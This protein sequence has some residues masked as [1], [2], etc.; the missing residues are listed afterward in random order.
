M[1]FVLLLQEG[2]GS[3]E[4]RMKTLGAV[5]HDGQSAALPGAVLRERRDDDVT[6]RLDSAK[7]RV[8]VG[9]TLFTRGEE[10]EDRPVVPDVVGMPRQ[11]QLRDV[12]R[13]PIH[14]RRPF[15]EASPRSRQ[16]GLGQVQDGDLLIAFCE[17]IIDQR[18][19]A[20]ANAMMLASFDTPVCAT[21]S[22]D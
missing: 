1:R 8:D 11:L 4:L 5:A 20:A 7:D 18:R 14:A 3:A 16:R 10:V 2:E 12:A 19:R 6:A 9:L 21:S 13:K 17:K 22:I 15:P